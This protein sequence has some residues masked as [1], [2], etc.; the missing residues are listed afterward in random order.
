MDN[1]KAKKKLTIIDEI[2]KKMQL[3]FFRL[4]SLDQFLMKKKTNFKLKYCTL[5]I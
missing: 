5:S 3:F 4:W 1:E 2:W